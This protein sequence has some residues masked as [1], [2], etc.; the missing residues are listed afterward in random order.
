MQTPADRTHRQ[1]AT[2]PAQFRAVA[3]GIGAS[4]KESMMTGMARD[5]HIAAGSPSHCMP[6]L[7]VSRGY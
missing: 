3:T 7:P 5:A 6:K 1:T 4:V 2:P